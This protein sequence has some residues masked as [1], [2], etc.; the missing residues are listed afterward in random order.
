MNKTY[1]SN[2]ITCANCVNLIKVS[3]EDEFGEI[4]VNLETSPKEITVDILSENH[5]KE[6]KKEM[7]S[8]GFDILD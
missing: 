7:K 6:F 3:L 5:E 1:K 8:L 4:S 2:K